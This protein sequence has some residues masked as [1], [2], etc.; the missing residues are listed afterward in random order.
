MKVYIKL[1]KKKINSK[2]Q[3]NIFNKKY[4][5]LRR[6]VVK[7][8]I[9]AGFSFEMIEAIEYILPIFSVYYLSCYYIYLVFYKRFLILLLN[10]CSYD[11]YIILIG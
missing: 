10:I 6:N 9:G 8:N 3:I 2:S 4:N 1:I 7:T 5:L 11:N